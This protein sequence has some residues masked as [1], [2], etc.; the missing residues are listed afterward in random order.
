M[1]AGPERG[2]PE[3]PG[4]RPGPAATGQTLRALLALLRCD[5]IHTSRLQVGQFPLTMMTLMII[6]TLRVGPPGPLF[7]F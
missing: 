5:K 1:R 6:S 4:L 3:R 2:D 7:L